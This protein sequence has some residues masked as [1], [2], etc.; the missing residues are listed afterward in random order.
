MQELSVWAPR[1]HTVALQ[2]KHTLIDMLKHADGWWRVSV[3]IEHGD[4]YGYWVDNQGPFPD[5]RSRWQP[6][7]AHGL[8]RYFAK[9]F[10]W[11][12]QQWRGVA[13]KEAIIYELHVGTFTQEGT[14]Q[15]IIDRLDHLCELGVTHIELLPVAQFSGEHGWGYDGVQLYAPHHAY[16][17]PDALM[18]LVD[19]CHAK[20]LGII[21]DVVYNHLGPSGN[22]LGHFAPYFHN[23]YHTPWGQ[24]VN[25]DGFHSPEVRRYFIDNAL[26]WLNDFH[27]DGLRLD[28][29]QTIMDGSAIHFLEQLAEEVDQLQAT[30]D[31]PL[32]LIAESHMNDSRL[33]LSRPNGGYGLQAQWHDD[34]HHA[35]Y[36]FLTGEQAGYFQDYGQ[37][38]QI[39]EV[40]NNGVYF[41]GQFC[42]YRQRLLGRPPEGLSG[43]N[44]V[45]YIQNHDQVGNRPGG[46]RLCHLL[47]LGQ[48][49]IAAALLLTSPFIPMLFQGEE[50]GAS[51]PF[52]YFTD[53]HE[54]KLAKDIK[55]GRRHEAQEFGWPLTHFSDPQEPDSF[56]R[57]QLSWDD[58]SG[59][60]N[61]ELL[62]WYKQLLVL[63][64]RHSSLQCG[65][66]LKGSAHVDAKS[67]VISV[68]RGDFELIC[69][70]SDSHQNVTARISGCK[71][72]L[73]SHGE[74]RVHSDHVSLPPHSAVLLD[75]LEL[76]LA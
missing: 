60:Q 32:I 58:M 8:S 56:T 30:Q 71:L 18:Q 10:S 48:M 19:A 13:H 69:N 50:W 70:C 64:R 36:A 20:G 35:V 44:F 40:L 11:T 16:G 4:D 42:H 7:G 25:V 55:R 51:T 49:K 59:D 47:N 17:S 2:H 61:H 41:H 28:A 29:V 66:F 68:I 22:Y 26:M 12:D 57:S 37:I 33:M 76:A 46:E 34:F 27:F 15:G 38:E 53:H 74:I 73:P 54:D 31:R 21:L 75:R 14:H 24:A 5:P 1:A 9:P 45:A 65:A 72:N 67:K 23:H 63:R 39:T 43:E 62:E 52:F 3:E 6:N